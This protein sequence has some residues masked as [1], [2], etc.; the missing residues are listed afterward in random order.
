MNRTP[1]HLDSLTVERD[2][3]GDRMSCRKEAQR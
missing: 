2:L 3:H 1:I